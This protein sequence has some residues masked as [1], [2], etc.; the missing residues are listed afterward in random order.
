MT[1]DADR[2]FIVDPRFCGPPQSGN[3]GYVSGR[4]A[5]FVRTSAESPDV[6]VTLRRPPPLGVR[7]E[8]TDDGSDGVALKYGETLVAQAKPARIAE[9][10]PDPVGYAE[11]VRAA[12]H[13]LGRAQHPFPTCFVCGLDRAAGDGLRLEPGA[14]APGV[15]A[16]T[17]QPETSLG[18]SP[19]PPE[20]GWAALDCPSGW[21]TDL[22]GRPMVLGRITA[23]LVGLP[24][25]GE[26]CVVVGVLRA[27]D[28]RKA[29][30]ASALYTADGEL[31]ARPGAEL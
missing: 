28:G 2:G 27:L 18:G 31:L 10:V 29:F 20:F 4:L 6:E 25:P 7:L 11:A 13:Y 8:V 9:P 16:A 21:A 1:G 14:V 24:D 5:A 17:W 22:G 3:G 12:E 26:P 19:L 15:V 30:T 23:R